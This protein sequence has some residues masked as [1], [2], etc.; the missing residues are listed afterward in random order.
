MVMPMNVVKAGE[1]VR[2]K[3][4]LMDEEKSKRFMEI[5]LTISNEIK[6]IQNN[7]SSL[8]LSVAGS[9]LGLDGSAARKI[10]VEQCI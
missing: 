2:V 4:F 1:S 7:G 9:R 3:R 6:V 5:G 8:I 10:M